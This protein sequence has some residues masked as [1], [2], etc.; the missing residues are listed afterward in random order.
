M[1]NAL[2]CAHVTCT[3]HVAHK[4]YE[5][6]SRVALTW[7]KV[8]PPRYLCVELEHQGS[9][10]AQRV[11]SRTQIYTVV[12]VFERKN[13]S[14][15]HVYMTKGQIQNTRDCVRGYLYMYIYPYISISIYIRIYMYIHVYI[16]T[17]TANLWTV[18]AGLYVHVHV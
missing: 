10:V 4:R 18:Q 14:I 13:K 15:L 6:Q 7:Q 16:H 5:R 17:C 2:E 11:T 8:C 1:S 3:A 9:S 12:R